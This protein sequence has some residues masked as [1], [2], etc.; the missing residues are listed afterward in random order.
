MGNNNET[1]KHIYLDTIKPHEAAPQETD[2]NRENL[3]IEISGATHDGEKPVNQDHFTII[4][5]NVTV[6]DGV[7]FSENSERVARYASEEITKALSELPTEYTQEMLEE[8]RETLI[9]IYRR[10]NEEILTNPELEGGL[11]TAVACK[12]ISIDGKPHVAIIN[13]GDSRAYLFRDRKLDFLTADENSPGKWVDNNEVYKEIMK[14]MET[15]RSKKSLAPGGRISSYFEA[16]GWKW[17]PEILHG[18]ENN[19]SYCL[20]S[21]E[22]FDEDAE[23][24]QVIFAPLLPDDLILLATD[25]VFDNNSYSE[26]VGLL[27]AQADDIASHVVEASFAHSKDDSREVH[28]K[29]DNITGAIIT[30]AKGETVEPSD[31]VPSPEV[32]SVDEQKIVEDTP[33]P[34]AIPEAN[35]PIGD[36]TT[37]R[38]VLK[39]KM[40]LVDES[41]FRMNKTETFEA[42]INA[43]RAASTPEEAQEILDLYMP[44]RQAASQLAIVDAK[45]LQLMLKASSVQI[46]LENKAAG[47]HKTVN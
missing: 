39:E 3:K 5:N 22:S 23:P 28:R 44:R 6:C 2:E 20:G 10:I 19:L 35:E 18:F 7:T 8:L 34:V 9:G 1:V 37:Y 45:V 11:T 13:R 42:F 36:F 24:P 15:M 41:I 26:L 47:S 31:N 40:D 32:E 14:L 17:D 33:L 29:S 38:D 46:E 43:A 16:K 30:V 12:I 21:E 4:G 25:G 27:S